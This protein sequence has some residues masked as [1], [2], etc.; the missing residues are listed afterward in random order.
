MVGRE[1]CAYPRESESCSVTFRLLAVALIALHASRSEPRHHDPYA[2]GAL[3][4]HDVEHRRRT[5]IYTFAATAPVATTPIAIATTTF[6]TATA[7]TVA[8]PWGD[9]CRV[10]QRPF[11]LG[12]ASTSDERQHEHRS[13]TLESRELH[14]R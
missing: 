13:T 1:A 8:D 2:W 10:L 4:S 14:R 3:I 7:S 6:F 11:T 12:Y 9:L 5:D